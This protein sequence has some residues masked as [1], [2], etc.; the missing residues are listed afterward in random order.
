MLEHRGAVLIGVVERHPLRTVG[1][2][3][4][5]RSQE[6]QR[7]SQGTV[8]R[9]KHGSILDLLRQREELLAQCMRRLMLGTHGVRWS[10]G[11]GPGD[12]ITTR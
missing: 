4:L 6:E 11:G 12:D 8:C 5:C 3:R 7:R 2:R 1:E 10:K 9:Y